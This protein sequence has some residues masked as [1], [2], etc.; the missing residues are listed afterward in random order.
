MCI[1][2]YIYG[3]IMHACTIICKHNMCC[4]YVGLCVYVRV[5]WVL[6]VAVHKPFRRD[7]LHEHILHCIVIVMTA[8]ILRH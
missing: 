7:F 8:I 5:G 1:Y 2:A 6:H 3:L 4:V